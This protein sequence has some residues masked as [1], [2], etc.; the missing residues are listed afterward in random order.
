MTSAKLVAIAPALDRARAQ[1]K[2]V[3]ERHP[4]PGETPSWV[5][6]D[7]FLTSLKEINAR[8]FSEEAAGYTAEEMAAVDQYFNHDVESSMPGE[9][10]C[11]C[12]TTGCY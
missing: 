5:G 11:S 1:M 4:V 12:A 7:A 2:A 8:N 10:L 9:R 6:L 3:A